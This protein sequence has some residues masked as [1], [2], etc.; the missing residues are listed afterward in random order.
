MY[1]ILK[2]EFYTG[3]INVIVGCWMCRYKA[4]WVA[5]YTVKMSTALY[6]SYCWKSCNLSVR[7]SSTLLRTNNIPHVIV[8]WCYVLLGSSVLM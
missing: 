8:T 4:C 6:G 1:V 5:V 2:S 7:I 3:L